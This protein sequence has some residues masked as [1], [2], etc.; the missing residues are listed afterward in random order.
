[1]WCAGE[2]LDMRGGLGNLMPYLLRSV[3][4]TGPMSVETPLD[5]QIRERVRGIM[6]DCDILLDVAAKVPPRNNG[7]GPAEERT[8]RTP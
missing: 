8:P 2:C 4:Q 6:V 7:A 3:R 5:I 1:M